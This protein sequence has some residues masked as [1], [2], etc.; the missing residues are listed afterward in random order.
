MTARLTAAP[1]EP[2]SCVPSCPGCDR[3]FHP[4][5]G[6]AVFIPHFV[7]IDSS[8]V[9]KTQLLESSDVV[10]KTGGFLVRLCPY[11]FLSFLGGAFVLFLSNPVN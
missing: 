9:L 10:L 7:F 2:T 11:F 3:V 4:S 5:D 8:L 6:L 1:V